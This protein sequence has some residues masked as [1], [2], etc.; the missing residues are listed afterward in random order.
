MDERDDDAALDAYSAVVTRVAEAVLPSVAAVS[1]R[2][3]TGAGAG[4]ASVITADGH[5][6]TSAHVVIGASAVELSFGDG[7]SMA[8]DV[9]GTDSLSD[10]AVLRARAGTPPPLRLGDASRLKVGQLVV[11][12]G[13]PLGLAGSVTAGIVSALGR[14][15]PTASGRVIDEVIQTDA[16]LNPG[17]SGGVLAD[18]AGRMIGVNTAVAGIGLGLAVPINASTLEIVEALKSSGRVRRAWLGVAGVKVQL[19]PEAAAKVGAPQGIRIASVVPGSPAAEAGARAGDIVISL[20][21]IPVSDPTGLQRLMVERAIGRRMEL[22]LWR[23]GALVDV[24]VLP[25]ELVG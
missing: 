13:N 4:S 25:Q 10:L 11:A 14:S 17:N 15:L 19:S 6:L 12:L 8:A 2:T 21:G 23:N 5:L 3:R 7:T 22:T 20:D 18:S 24:V 16:A 9:A 1:V